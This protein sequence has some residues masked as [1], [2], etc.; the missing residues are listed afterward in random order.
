MTSRIVKFHNFNDQYRHNK[1]DLRKHTLIEFARKI[2]DKLGYEVISYIDFGTFGSA[3][4]IT[5]FSV[6]KLTTDIREVYTAKMLLNKEPEHIVNY[7]NV[8]KIES[9]FLQ[10]DVYALIMDYVFSI[11]DGESKNK[12]FFDCFTYNFDDQEDFFKNNIFNQKHIN[13]FINEYKE[14]YKNGLSDEQINKN[15][16]ELMELAMEA[17]QLNIYP[18]DVHS[19]NLGYKFV[20]TNL[21]YFDVGVNKNYKIV[22]IDILLI[23]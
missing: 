21:V 3:F 9:E 20:D 1:I 15:I 13:T 23:D 16:Q 2:A 5:K 22:P 11:K 4:K 17:K 7:H 14:K 6:L 12:N 19:G 10:N 18:L 8:K